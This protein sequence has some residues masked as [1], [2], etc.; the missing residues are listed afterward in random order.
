MIKFDNLFEFDETVNTMDGAVKAM[1]AVQAS[2]RRKRHAGFLLR[3]M[4][5]A[6]ETTA[7]DEVDRLADACDDIA[8]LIVEEDEVAFA[9]T[10]GEDTGV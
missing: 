5:A 9:V 1:Q 7:E 4:A 3:V 6:L 10:G 8:T 2:A